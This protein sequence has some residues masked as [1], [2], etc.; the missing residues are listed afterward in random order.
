VCHAPL[1]APM[2]IVDE[3][4]TDQDERTKITVVSDFI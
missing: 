3:T 2:T 1:E 4:A